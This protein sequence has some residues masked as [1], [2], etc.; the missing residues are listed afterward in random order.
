MCDLNVKIML[1]T[2]NFLDTFNDYEFFSNVV[3]NCLQLNVIIL[4]YCK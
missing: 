1:L 2:K 3:T 4:H